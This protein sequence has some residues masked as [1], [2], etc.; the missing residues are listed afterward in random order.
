MSNLIRRLRNFLTVVTICCCIAPIPPAFSKNDTKNDATFAGWLDSSGTADIASVQQRAVWEPFSGW[1]GWGFGP[2]PVWLKVDLPKASKSDAPP[3]ILIVRPEYLDS[4]TLY[5][6]YTG[7]EQRTGDF[8]PPQSNISALDSVLFSFEIPAV[9]EPRSIF[10]RIQTTSTRTVNLSLMSRPEARSYLRTVEWITVSVLLASLILFL[11]A[12]VQ[13]MQGKDRLMGYFCIRQLA[14]V[15]WGFMYSGFAWITIGTWFREGDLSLISGLILCAAVAASFWFYAVLLDEYEAPKWMMTSLKASALISLSLIFLMILGFRRE[16][17]QIVNAIY[18]LGIWWIPLAVLLIKRKAIEPPISKNVML[19]YLVFMAAVNSIAPFIYIGLI[20]VSSTVSFF[21]L[22]GNKGSLVIDGLIMMSMMH[23]RHKRM[24]QESLALKNELINQEEK[25]KI[26]QHFLEEQRKIM[27]MLAH[28]MKTPLASMRLWMESG[29]EGKPKMERAIRDMD[30]VIERC[31]HA[32]QMS[33]PRLKPRNHN[34]DAGELTQSVLS[35]SR[36]PE[37]VK[38]T[39]SSDVCMLCA[40]EQMTSIVLSNLFENAYKYSAPNTQI[41]V[42]LSPHIGENGLDGWQWRIENAV[43][44][45]GYPDASRVFEKYYRSNF[46]QR[47]SGTGLGLFLV[48]SLLD[49]MGGRISY[50][51]L[52]ES[53]CF[54]LWLPRAATED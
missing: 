1:K 50:T 5:D 13:W 49:L 22:L 42:R 6:P 38:L 46:A 41:E 8:Y 48:K 10:L 39:L 19:A 23:M 20:E 43:V 16:S 7:I 34:F 12:I 33:D 2:E 24:R 25:S 31:V 27:A 44:D 29:P 51:P 15:L 54:E 37:R 47:Q 11:W 45:Q 35:K 17:L 3:F 32:Q 21:L 9:G 40:D 53:V 18:A 4:L 30:Q 26:S 36:Q 14:S 28:E 52:S